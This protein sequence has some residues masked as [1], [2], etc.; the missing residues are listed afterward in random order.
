MKAKRRRGRIIRTTDPL[1]EKLGFEI[2]RGSSIE[3]DGQTYH[4]GAFL[5]GG[6]KVALW[7][8][9]TQPQK[10]QSS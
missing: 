3:L 10:G 6:H 1:Q 2:L 5:E 9:S 4:V 7:R 8:E